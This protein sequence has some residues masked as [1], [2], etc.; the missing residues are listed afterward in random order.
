MYAKLI[1]RARI[2]V[3]VAMA[4]CGTGAV[5]CANLH[6]RFWEEVF[7]IAVCGCVLAAV[8]LAFEYLVRAWLERPGRRLPKYQFSLAGL[9]GLTTGVAV[10]CSCCKTFGAAALV[11]LVVGLTIIASIVEKVCRSREN[12][13]GH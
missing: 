1:D 11:W 3:A 6:Y 8:G 9:L 10:V 13:G 12:K 5:V 2:A 7:E 4:V